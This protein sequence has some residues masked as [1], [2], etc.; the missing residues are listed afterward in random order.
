MTDPATPTDQPQLRACLRGRAYRWRQHHKDRLLYPLKR[1]GPRGE[2]SFARISWDEALDLFAAELLRIRKTYGNN[3]L[4]VPYGTGSYN[5]TNGRWTAERLLHL[6]GGCVDYYNSYSWACI[7]AATPTVYGTN[8]TGNDR[9]DWLNS[10]LILMWSWNPAEMRDGTNSEYFIKKARE[11]GR[12][13]RLPRSPDDPE[14][15]RPGRRMDPDPA[16]DG[17]RP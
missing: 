14:R 3:A 4:F 16:R 15:R 7:S 10:Q 12:P 13:G 5:Q 2:A 17:R 11:R 1:I 8:I 6:F 9:R